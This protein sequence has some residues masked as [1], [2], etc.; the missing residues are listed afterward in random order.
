M[1]RLRGTQSWAYDTLML[2]RE[3]LEE[4]MAIFN[5]ADAPDN[6]TIADT[7]TEYESLDEMEKHRGGYVTELVIRSKT[8][9]ITLHLIARPKALN[10]YTLE[11]TDEADATFYRANSFLQPK[12]RTLH[13]FFTAYIG[14]FLIVLLAILL[15]LDIAHF[16]WMIKI[17]PFW[18]WIAAG[19]TLFYLISKAVDYVDKS[20]AA[21]ICLKRKHEVP[22]FFKR[23]EDRLVIA[24]ASAVL[25]I[26]GT[27]I[28][29]RIL[30]P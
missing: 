14:L 20:Q 27:L 25:S 4:L 1:K 17:L 16:S 19:G 12:R 6:I 30:K 5:S 21:L 18:L 11:A 2:F 7:Q 26:I 3:D 23:N 8:P 24:V 13:K 10:L 9:R 28:V 15:Y 29:Q 22:N